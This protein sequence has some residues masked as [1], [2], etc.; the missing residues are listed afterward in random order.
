MDALSGT[1][2]IPTL[3]KAI[4]TTISYY[5]YK[6]PDNMIWTRDDL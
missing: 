2:Q 6:N 5:K 1:E 3:Q 4:G